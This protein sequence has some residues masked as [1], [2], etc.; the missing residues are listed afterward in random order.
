MTV[1][2]DTNR[3]GPY[4]GNGVTT[5]FDYEF[6]IVDEN[7]IKVIKADA[8]GVETI[9]TIDA[10]YVVS[11]VGNP[12]G[13]QVALT[14]ALPVGYTLTLLR[15]VPF[16]QETDLENQGAYYA[17]TVEAALDLATMRSQQLQEQINRAVTIPP[18]EDPAQLDGLVHDVLRLADSADN[19]DTVATNIA[20]VN[21]AA[22]NI[23]A[24]IA[25]PA[26]AAAAAA[27]A[28]TAD[29]SEDFARKWA[30]EAEDVAVNDGVNPAGFSAFHWMRKALG[31]AASAS[32][33]AIAAAASAAS[34]A[35]PAIVANTFLQAKP[36]GTGYL[37]KTPTEVRN[38]LAAAAFVADRTAVKALD[39]T[40][41]KAATTYGEGGRNG[42]WIAYLT[43]SLT[44]T[45]Q[46]AAAADASEAIYLVDG[47][48]TWIRHYNGKAKDT[49]WGTAHDNVAD[50]APALQ[51]AFNFIQEYD[52]PLELFPRGNYKLN[53]GLTVKHGQSNVDTKKYHFRLAGNDA[54]FLPA[55]GITALSIVPRCTLADKATGRGEAFYDIE[56]LTLYGSASATAKGLVVGAAGMW[57]SNFGNNRLHNVIAQNF[58]G[59]GAIT[60]TECRKIRATSMVC[61]GAQLLLQSL[62]A[63]SIIGDLT[64]DFL[65]ITGSTVALPGLKINSSVAV[66][67]VEARGIVFN[68][69]VFYASGYTMTA[70]VG[71]LVGDIWFNSAQ[72]DA[73]VAGAGN[74]AM[75]VATSGG[76]K[77]NGIHF[78]QPYIVNHTSEALKVQAASV[79]DITDFNVVA[80][81]IGTITCDTTG[82]NSA[83][84]FVKVQGLRVVAPGFTMITAGDTNS[85]YMRFFQCADWVLSA[86][87]GT[88]GSAMTRGV[89][90]DG[91]NTNYKVFGC[92]LDVT[93]AT[94]QILDTDLHTGRH[95]F[96]NKGDP[97]LAASEG[98]SVPTIAGTT[99]AGA[100][101]Y[102]VQSLV[103]WRLGKLVHFRATV[104]WSAHTGTGN[105]QLVPG[106]GGPPNAAADTPVSVTYDSLTYTSTPQA[107]IKNGSN[108]VAFQMA[109]TNAA[110]AGLPIEAAAT[111]TVAGSYLTT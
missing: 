7:H 69:P 28:A 56:N 88:G 9:L 23:A 51:A 101:T 54:Q 43:S 60:M 92:D 53:T 3:S 91:G 57:C 17:E 20:D 25:A 105:I 78:N 64:F 85:S 39:P 106:A 33:S 93:V 12:A 10:D 80:A 34:I 47:A 29:T 4:N 71:A 42:T 2:S 82:F 31:Y 109:A 14:V 45:E 79:G 83:M 104:T 58:T 16:T 96:G 84:T 65:E 6:R 75:S 50:D 87:T 32:A 66:G 22:D 74:V 76:G 5:V 61:R 107:Y 100:G 26:Q 59:A 8:A 99:T 19:I 90:I 38:A 15:N 1:P 35:L 49:W 13:G 111:V 94:Q 40:K 27:S 11:D 41:D 18:S 110:A 72:W 103:W 62:T 95:V 48:Y 55:N 70:G 81:Q 77:M 52:I 36:D 30:T 89:Q 73:G 46:A 44:A 67:S 21:T 86:P 98:T 63:G 37:T 24:I 108:T 97:Y 102:S 68:R